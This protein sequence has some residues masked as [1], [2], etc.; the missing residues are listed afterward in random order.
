[1]TPRL[2]PH[3]RSGF[4]LIELSVGL[5]ASSFLLLG[6]GSSIFL[7]TQANRVD[8]GPFR[9]SSQGASAIDEVS[10]ELSYATAVHSIT[11]ARNIQVEVP[12]RT[13]DAV[14]DVVRYQWSGTAGDPL[15][16]V[17]NGGT[18][19]N[20]IPALQSFGLTSTNRTVTVKE[21]G[22]ATRTTG[23]VNWFEKSSAVLE[24]TYSLQAAGGVGTDFLPEF[25]EGA[26]TWSL[27][28]VEVYCQSNGTADGV[29][30]A[31]LWT[32][33]SSRKPATLLAETT[34]TE[35]GLSSS[36]NWT[37]ITFPSAPMVSVGQRL[38]FTLQY[39]SGPSIVMQVRCDDLAN[40]ILFNPYYRLTTA[41]AGTT[42]SQQV[43]KALFMRVYGY[44]TH[45]A[46]GIVD[47]NR[48]FMTTV[49]L[50]AQA[51]TNSTARMRSTARIRNQPA[52][53]P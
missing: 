24:G 39:F 17:F 41:N 42:W 36:M 29:I 44:Y 13:G 4:S 16:R 50:E 20:V 46:V 37:T 34:V 25:P 15:Q 26:Q 49:G 5:V 12:D 51:G 43:E 23:V 7:A 21:L 48:T 35:S 1:M 45:S 32:A 53:T 14:A 3:P 31:R 11:P 8:I 10:R 38:C 22:A 6:L 28:K 33:D 27:S 19:T 2:R 9:S 40:L 52:V 47:V 30:K 18:A